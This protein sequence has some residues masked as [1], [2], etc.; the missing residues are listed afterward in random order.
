MPIC[1]DGTEAGGP[2]AGTRGLVD[3]DATDAE[4][5]GP[6]DCGEKAIGGGV[7]PIPCSGPADSKPGC[8]ADVG[9]M[10]ST[11]ETKFSG[12]GGTSVFTVV[13]GAAIGSG[14]GVGG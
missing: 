7:T 5:A 10:L 13:M 14:G 6:A 2:S 3:G 11:G 9:M 12:S 4:A 1:T 8:G